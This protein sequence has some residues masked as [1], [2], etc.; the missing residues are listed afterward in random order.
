[1]VN[2]VYRKIISPLLLLLLAYSFH[3]QAEEQQ[4]ISINFRDADIQQVI[5]SIAEL[6]GKNFLAGRDQQASD[7]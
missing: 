7:C 2:I 3:V 6:T 4:G 1:M 5:E